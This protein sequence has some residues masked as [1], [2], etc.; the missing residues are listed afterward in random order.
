MARA[1]GNRRLPCALVQ[2]HAKGA[3]RSPFTQSTPARALL[4]CW[5][6]AKPAPTED[7]NTAAGTISVLTLK[8]RILRYEHGVRNPILDVVHPEVELT[9]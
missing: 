1:Q 3:G 4:A 5:L 6:P 8:Y 2:H 7:R 9:Y